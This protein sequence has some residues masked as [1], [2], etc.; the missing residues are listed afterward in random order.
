MAALRHDLGERE[1][2]ITRRVRSC[3][4]RPPLVEIAEEIAR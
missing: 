3:R 2:S 1:Q 4:T